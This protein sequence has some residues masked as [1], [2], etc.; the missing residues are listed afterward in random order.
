MTEHDIFDLCK[1]K[2]DINSARKREDKAATPITVFEILENERPDI[3]KQLTDIK[4]L[5]ETASAYTFFSYVLNTNDTRHKFISALGD[6]VIDPLEEFMTICLSY[7]RT[8]PGTLHHFLKWFITGAS[9]IKRD[10]DASAGV[11]IV[12]VHGSKGLESRVVFLIDTVR[13][14]KSENILP[15]ESRNDM[16]VWLWTPR[17][18]QVGESADARDSLMHVR[19]AEYYRLLYVAMTRA[20]DE[21]YIYG[22]TPHKNAPENAWYTQLWR[23]FAGPDTPEFI[24]ITNEDI[25]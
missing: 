7:E 17:G 6:Q 5:S 14:P 1:I 11:R 20:R 25:A 19:M 10:M 9:E 2:Y 24:R 23:V 15:I 8:Q 4:N 21:L 12:T 22:Y 13:T 3:Y 16:P 18:A